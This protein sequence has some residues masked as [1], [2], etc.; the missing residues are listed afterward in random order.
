[1]PPA[2]EV[3]IESEVAAWEVWEDPGGPIAQHELRKQIESAYEISPPWRL[4]QLILTFSAVASRRTPRYLFRTW[5]WASGGNAALDTTKAIT[6]LAFHKGIGR[7]S[8]H[9]Y[10]RSVLADLADQHYT[11]SVNVD[12][13][14][15]SWSGSLAF[16]LSFASSRTDGYISIVDTKRL[17][18]HN[19]FLHTCSMSFIAPDFCG[20]AHEFLGFG[21][22]SGSAH[23]A[24]PFTKLLD[25][26]LH[27]LSAPY[28]LSPV[29]DYEPDV[30]GADYDDL[31]EF[32][33]QDA[34]KEESAEGNPGQLRK[35][36]VDAQKLGRHFGEDFALPMS[37][38]LLCLRYRTSSVSEQIVAELASAA[39]PE[40]WAQDRTIMGEA[41][42]TGFLEDTM[43][44][45]V[46]MRAL[47]KRKLGTCTGT[48]VETLES[49][50]KK[51]LSIAQPAS[52][53][54]SIDMIGWQRSELLG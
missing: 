10:S 50:V 28:K 13:P 19:V 11:H 14:F 51:E 20:G 47:V 31:D 44:S 34:Q 45:I 41:A 25:N 35:L 6:P 5:N 4:A 8:I 32:A 38:Y 36:L 49:Q 27:S 22:I 39:I 33:L 43:R 48:G 2:D 26:G 21:V 40:K 18:K 23:K 16:V 42:S 1:M 7:S 12:T 15:S 46:L 37:V 53:A 3:N 54:P 30:D 52:R 29:Y 17:P 9:A 24:V